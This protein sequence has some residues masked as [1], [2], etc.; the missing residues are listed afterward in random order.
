MGRA[1]VL[2]GSVRGARGGSIVGGSARSWIGV[3][4]G[5]IVWRG[6]LWVE[7]CVECGASWSS[8]VG[9]D[10]SVIWLHM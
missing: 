6:E 7:C 4:I 10:V 9:H 5:L 2:C 1:G 3:G 8:F